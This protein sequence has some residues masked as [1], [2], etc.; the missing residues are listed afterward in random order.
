MKMKKLIAGTFL[1]AIAFAYVAACVDYADP[2]STVEAGAPSL[3]A[4]TKDSGVAAPSPTPAPTGAPTSQPDAAGACGMR[5]FRGGTPN[6]VVC[7]GTESCA[8]GSTE[9][10]CMQKID[11]LTGACTSLSAC[12]GLALQCD[13]PED[14]DGGVCCLE[15][16]TGGGSSCKAAGSCGAGQWL[17]RTDA[18]CI[19]APPGPSCAPIDLGAAGVDDVGLDGIVG[20]CGK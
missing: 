16:R 18:D 5:S 19:G 20:V 12:R 3:A 15:D 7:P 1:C 4:T 6:A 13:G 2:N 9:I 11:A 17:C 10:C 8:C 14:C